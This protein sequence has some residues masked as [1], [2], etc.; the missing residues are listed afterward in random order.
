MKLTILDFTVYGNR[1]DP[2]SDAL[3]EAAA[4]KLGIETTTLVI[5]RADAPAIVPTENVWLR[6]DVRSRDDLDLMVELARRLKGGQHRVFPSAQAILAAGDKWETY[7]VLW[8]SGVHVPKTT[9]A[10]QWP[11]TERPFIIKP[12]IGWGGMGA[13]VVRNDADLGAHRSLLNKRHVCQPF[14]A[15]TRTLTVAL[16]GERGVVCIEDVGTGPKP[17]RRTEV[18]PLTLGATQ[19]AMF[20]L[21]ATGLVA[22]TVDLIGSPGGLRVLEVNSSP[23]LTYPHL[24]AADLAAPMVGA[25][26]EKVFRA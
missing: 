8:Q 23:R 18:A 1:Y 16:A 9:L 10:P 5:S 6:Y 24:P 3:L 14:I 15:H 19:Q 21:A 11:Q 2:A 7:R 17:E 12:R 25:V 22:G 26:V 4:R 13:A 20:A